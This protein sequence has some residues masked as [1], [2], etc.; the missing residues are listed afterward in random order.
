[1]NEKYFLQNDLLERG[2]TKPL[3][4][5]F[6][7]KPDE[8]RHRC[9]GG[10][11]YLLER[12]RTL[13][14]EKR[15]LWQSEVAKREA[16][17][18]ARRIAALTS[19]SNDEHLAEVFDQH[20]DESNHWLDHPAIGPYMAES[21]KRK[22][23]ELLAEHGILPAL[24]AIN[25]EAKRQRDASLAAYN[26]GDHDEATRCKRDKERLYWLKGQ[27]LEHLWREGEVE[28]V[29]WHRFK[30]HLVA[31]VFAGGGYRF[32]RPALKAPDGVPVL[33]LKQIEAKPHE[34][35]EVLAE[36]AEEAVLG[37][38]Q[39][40]AEIEVY[41]WPERERKSAHWRDDWNDEV[42][43]EDNGF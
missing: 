3:I 12:K 38:L 17:R 39:T 19:E 13:R 20:G 16:R 7:G 42:D 5:K 15:K 33:G 40:R 14:A 31:E 2:W 34:A 6:L 43:L 23:L 28:R 35:G 11:Y 27:A 18:K 10:E 37:F 1:M 32:H 22:Q 26:S 25:R 9:G 21:R 24:F 41:E 30:G 4:L 29:G 36:Q 8:I